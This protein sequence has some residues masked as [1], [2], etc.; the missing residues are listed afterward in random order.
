[1]ETWTWTWD[2]DYDRAYAKTDDP[3][4]LAV[5]ERDPDPL[6]PDG[7][8]FAPAYRF[9]DMSHMSGTFEDDDVAEAYVRAVQEWG[10][11]DARVPR[12]LRAFYGVLGYEIVRSSIYWSYK[13]IIFDTVA[14][15]EH[16]GA[17]MTLP[18]EDYLVGDVDT[19][20]AYLDDEVYGIG[21]AV[22]PSRVMDN[23]EPID[24]DD[25]T[26]EVELECWGYYGRDWAQEAALQFEA[27]E[28]YLEPLLP[29]VKS[30]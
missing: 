29:L 28:P 25:D 27:G 3:R 19:W 15:R 9:D 22:N 17:P 8:G 18:S 10:Q 20:Q 1:M 24:L 13:V 14:H 2:R 7:D 23:G 30:A 4:L 26:W 21:W 12:Y 16:V 11:D 5:I 6:A